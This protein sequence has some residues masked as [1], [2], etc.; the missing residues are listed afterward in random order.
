M[1]QRMLGPN[2]ASATALAGEIGIAQ[3]T[4]SRWL[5]EASTLS[6]MGKRS[7]KS[8]GAG[9]KKKRPQ[10][11]SV[12]D[13]LRLVV[14]AGA[15]S[16]EELGEFLRRNGIHKA[17]LEQWSSAITEALE[18][19]AKATARNPEAKKVRHLER[20]LLRKDK[21]LAEAAALLVLKKKARAIWGDEDDDT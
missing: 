15:L 9:V 13:K 6:G 17:Q 18:T 20:E 7:G 19:K 14:E 1:V 12:Q 21:A 16:E 11:L 10:D 2:A 4:L 3:P 5:R 8:G